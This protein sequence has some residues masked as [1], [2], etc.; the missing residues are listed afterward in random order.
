MS[1]CK[2]AK[3][4]SENT[5]YFKPVVARH[6]GQ[7][8]KVKMAKVKFEHELKAALTYGCL[9]ACQLILDNHDE[10]P[11]ESIDEMRGDLIELMCNAHAEIKKTLGLKIP[12]FSVESAL[13]RYGDYK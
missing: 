3:L 2:I 12:D 10:D 6:Y 1:Q 7:A 9:N 5:N 8:P 11:Y 4:K 13:T